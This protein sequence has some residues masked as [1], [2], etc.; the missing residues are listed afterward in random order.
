MVRTVD[1]VT[2]GRKFSRLRGDNRLVKNVLLQVRQGTETAFIFPVDKRKIRAKL[3][4]K[5]KLGRRNSWGRWQTT[6][7]LLP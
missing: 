6:K 4:R 1:S 7:R 2:P 3:E 5:S